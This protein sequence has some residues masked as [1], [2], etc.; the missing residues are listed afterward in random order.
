ML[1]NVFHYWCN[2]INSS[3][4]KYW[5][6]IKLIKQTIVIALFY[7]EQH[8]NIISTGVM[9]RYNFYAVF[10]FNNVSM[11]VQHRRA[12][13]PTTVNIVFYFQEKICENRIL[14][15]LLLNQLISNQF[16][17]VSSMT[18][19]TNTFWYFSHATDK[20]YTICLI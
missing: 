9:R 19:T 7:S 5:L 16:S 10:I 6:F 13:I 14:Q 12:W 8:Q 3:Y 11:Y 18:N 2:F 4:L 15:T 17:T 20:F 1:Q